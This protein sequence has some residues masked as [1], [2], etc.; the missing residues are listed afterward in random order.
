MSSTRN[1]PL[2]S[3]K[4]LSAPRIAVRFSSSSIDAIALS[5]APDLRIDHFAISIHSFFCVISSSFGSSDFDSAAFFV[6]VFANSTS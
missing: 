2:V 4:K 3:F 5:S 6:T 1:A